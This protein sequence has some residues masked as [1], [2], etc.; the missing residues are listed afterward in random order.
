MA[1]NT[2]KENKI[3]C[4]D[5]AHATYMQWFENPIIAMCNMRNERMVA[6]SEHICGMYQDA[7]PRKPEIQHFDCYSDND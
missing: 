5:C 2:N 4:I 1:K 6:E 3:R 7:G